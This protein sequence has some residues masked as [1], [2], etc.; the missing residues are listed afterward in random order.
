[1]PA[2]RRSVW[3]EG[4]WGGGNQRPFGSGPWFAAL[5]LRWAIN[6]IALIIAA[7]V[8]PGIELRGWESTLIAAAVFGLINAVIRPLVLCL[9]C[10]LQILTLGLFT[11]VVN[12]AMLALTAWVAGPLG[13]EF[14]VVDFWAAFLGAL[15][16]TVVSFVLTRFVPSS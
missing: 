15:V 10:L 7:A 16:I 6:A 3:I 5:L 11:L 14:E 1:M 13:L 12:A 2:A 8:V 4:R 9:T